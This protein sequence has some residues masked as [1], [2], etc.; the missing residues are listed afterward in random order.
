MLVSIFLDLWFF[1]S[2]EEYNIE[3]EVKEYA[4]NQ[5]SPDL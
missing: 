1:S 4:F 3:I 2:I 5:L